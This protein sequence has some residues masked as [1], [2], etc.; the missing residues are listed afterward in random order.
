MYSLHWSEWLVI[1]II[2]AA[3]IYGCVA[4]SSSRKKAAG[5]VSADPAIRNQVKAGAV[6]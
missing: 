3:G 6:K 1:A 2:Y 5:P 4:S